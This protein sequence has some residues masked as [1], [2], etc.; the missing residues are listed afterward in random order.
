MTVYNRPV[1]VLLNTLHALGRNHLED[2]EIIIV[3]DASTD[4]KMIVAARNFIH[5]R[6]MEVL[7]Y[8]ILSETDVYATIEAPANPRQRTRAARKRRSHPRKGRQ[9]DAPPSAAAARR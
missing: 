2:T 9:P 6:N 1:R 3:D 4:E 7:E 5:E 8:V